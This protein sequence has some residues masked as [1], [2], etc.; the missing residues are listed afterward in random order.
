MPPQRNP[1]ARPNMLEIE[2]PKGNVHPESVDIP[3]YETV[4]SGSQVIGTIN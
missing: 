1:E 3:V 2:G 4:P